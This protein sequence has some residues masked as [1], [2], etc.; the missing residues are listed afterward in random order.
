MM[1][2]LSRFSKQMKHITSSFHNL[3]FRLNPFWLQL[4]YITTLS[5]FGFLALKATKPRTSTKP[6]NLDLFFTSVSASTLSSMSTVEMEVFSNT[7]L[8]F[9]ALLMFLGSEVF[10][11]LLGLHLMRAKK[12]KNGLS[13]SNVSYHTENLDENE[14]L[15]L[16]MKIKCMKTLSC[17]VSCYLFV[18]HGAGL[19]LIYIYLILNPAAKKVLQTKGINLSTFSIFT[20]VSAISNSGFTPTNENMVA[21]M[22]NP[23]LLLILVPQLM[24]GNMLYPI[25]LRLMILLMAKTTRSREYNYI[26][27]NSGE[28]GYGHLIPWQDTVYLGI[29][30]FGLVVVQ[31]AV[32]SALEWNSEAVV[33]GGLSVYEKVVGIFFQVVNSRHT[34]EV[35]FD[36][37]A[38][39][40][41]VLLMFVLMMYL[42]PYTSY[43][44]IEQA[45]NTVTSRGEK[46]TR[47]NCKGFLDNLIFSQLTYLFIFIFLI[48]LTERHKMKTDPLNFNV[49]NIVFEVVSAYGNV[50][51]TVGYSC[52]K[53]INPD[54]NCKDAWFGF[55]GKWSDVAKLILAIVMIFGRLK[56]FNKRGGRAWNL[57]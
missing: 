36:L 32:F 7:H 37:S 41:A 48:C 56:K 16:N 39:S 54:A 30:V 38:V 5:S 47:S 40:Q 49:L 28:L 43:L 2:T 10:T 1:N 31:M 15:N 4:F 3:L 9:L 20:T 24:M 42:P 53:Q 6:K 17:T 50:G 51:F 34:G 23:G 57:A 12:A 45:E 44:P 33:G 19:A 8:V 27:Q 14:N 52:E 11:S 26:L 22:K 29:T 13:R 35:V 18:A 55:V 46:N 25:M 21:F